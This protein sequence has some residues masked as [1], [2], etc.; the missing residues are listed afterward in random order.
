M[1]HSYRPVDVKAHD[2]SRCSVNDGLRGTKDRGNGKSHHK[3]PN[4]LDKSRESHKFIQ[5][6]V[7]KTGQ[8][9]RYDKHHKVLE[10]Q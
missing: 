9:D 2:L 6:K 3:T 1:R 4:L 7:S 10:N 5:C 8:V